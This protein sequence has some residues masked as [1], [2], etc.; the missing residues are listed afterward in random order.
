M[1]GGHKHY[2]QK[3]TYLTLDIFSKPSRLLRGSKR[4]KS[5]SPGGMPP[6]KTPSPPFLVG[7]APAKQVTLLWNSI[8]R[9][10]ILLLS[11]V[12]WLQAC[13]LPGEIV[14]E[15]ATGDNLPLSVISPRT[16]LPGSG[17]DGGPLYASFWLRDRRNSAPN[18]LGAFYQIETEKLAQTA[19]LVLYRDSSQTSLM[20]ASQAQTLLTFVESHLNT[21]QQI[22]GDGVF[23]E[24][25]PQQRLVIVATNILDDYNTTGQFIAGFFA[26]RDLFPDAFTSALYTSPLLV[27]RY[28]IA[29]VQLLRGRSNENAIFYL[30][31]NP[32]FNG[33][34]FN[35]NQ[36]TAINYLKDIMLHELS[37]LFTWHRRVTKERLS[38]HDLWITEGL[39]ENAPHLI[40]NTTAAFSERL[41]L[42][43]SPVMQAALSQAPSLLE[44]PDNGV[45]YIQ[46]LLFFGYL[47][48]R[49]A[50]QAENQ[51]RQLITAS[52]PSLTGLQGMVNL[53]NGGDIAAL[54]RDYVISS[55]VAQLG[56]NLSTL[57]DEDGN[58]VS[59]GDGSP[60][61]R[62]YELSFQGIGLQAA[63]SVGFAFV[64][65]SLP[66]AYETPPG[67]C[68]KPLSY[69]TFRYTHNSATDSCAGSN[70][71]Y[72]TT[73]Y[74]PTISG[75]HAALRFFVNTVSEIPANTNITLHL[76]NA[77][78]PIANSLFT[79]CEI[80][81]FTVY[82][83]QTSGA[84]LALGTLPIDERNH[85]AW[86]GAGANGWQTGQG[87]LWG[88]DAGYFYRPAGIAFF[89]DGSTDYLYVADY[90]NMAI[91][92]Y[93]ATDGAFEGRLG[94]TTGEDCTADSA[95]LDGYFYGTARLLNSHCRRSLFEPRALA[96]DSAGN[97][98]I[99]DTGNMRIVKYDKDGNFI[100]WLGLP[101]SSNDKWQCE[102]TSTA[103]AAC[104]AIAGTGT[105][106]PLTREQLFLLSNYE[107]DVTMFYIPWGIAVDEAN[108][109]L[110]VVNYG[111][112]RVVR[113]K[114]STGEFE[115]YIGNGQ[116]TS[117]NGW[118]S[119]DSSQNPHMGAGV[120]SFKD[121]TGISQ[122]AGYLYITDSGNHR[123]V[124]LKKS[125]FDST[126]FE[127]LGGTTQ[128]WG[129]HSTPA[130]DNRHSFSFPLDVTTDNT[131]LYV[132]DRNNQRLVR[133]KISD[134]E[135]SW[136]GGGQ[137]AWQPSNLSPGIDPLKGGT[138][139]LPTWYLE[140]QAVLAVPASMANASKNY[141]YSTAVYNGRL[142]RVNLN[143]A[144]DL[145]GGDCTFGY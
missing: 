101:K 73:T 48:H 32:T 78:Q 114:L 10:P 12:V 36:T 56:R 6:V 71:K 107:N 77:S 120:C 19:R 123:L 75:S 98:Y 83:P 68:L 8:A 88:T 113:R 54:Y 74:T 46:S 104:R 57:Y 42:Q 72:I 128:G 145:I 65:N 103:A 59:L 9:W 38:L 137:L 41:T 49:L 139:Y 135:G 63:G 86:L 29:T 39:A 141:L 34:G 132:A 25:H 80:Y 105:A 91:T 51:F 143:C 117:C 112:R 79:N 64:S 66:I 45:G 106:A 129:L 116:P 55:Y 134:G 69:F 16:G 109:H 4:S 127:W 5:S 31:L 13:A 102:P 111:A 50:T 40:A 30:D 95:I 47:R 94:E 44:F 67:N 97:L 24:I 131:Y 93:K 125:S 37:H 99:S 108:D 84:C 138:Q 92:R 144:A 61:T 3:I 26:P 17:A 133:R 7:N 122:D 121:P 110:Y 11:T 35:N 85:S 124:R 43:A 90:I 118:Q 119:S 96:T 27:S 53:I 18:S 15:A 14:F 21:L 28:D 52:S 126:H 100:A 33:V 82:N 62:K 58:P 20:D 2:L 23:P 140:P 1:K 130:G 142:S 87:A 81:Q 76:F 89:K 22:Y 115:A 70:P 136:L 60:G